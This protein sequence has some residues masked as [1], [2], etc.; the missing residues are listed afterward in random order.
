ME[1]G[2]GRWEIV[3]KVK[4]SLKNP[5]TIESGKL[6]NMNKNRAENLWTSKYNNR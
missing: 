1:E 4:L 5:Q 3:P 6:V 2:I